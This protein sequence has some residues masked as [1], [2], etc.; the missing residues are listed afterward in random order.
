MVATSTVE[1]LVLDI[2]SINSALNDR[3]SA[4][5]GDEI[6]PF[7]D[8]MSANDVKRIQKQ[9]RDKSY[10]R[11]MTIEKYGAPTNTKIRVVVSGTVRMSVPARGYGNILADV[12]PELSRLCPSV[13]VCKLGGGDLTLTLTLTLI[14]GLQARGRRRDRHVS[15]APPLSAQ[16]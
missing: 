6:F 11:G 4:L 3:E 5:T 13:E 14:G 1:C 8:T 2:K 10:R 16:P 9:A 7:V 15:Y 12:P